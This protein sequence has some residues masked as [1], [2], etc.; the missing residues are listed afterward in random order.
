M[1]FFCSLY[2]VES[3]FVVFLILNLIFMIFQ[4]ICHVDIAAYALSDF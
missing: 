3:Y 2:S 4:N 1:N